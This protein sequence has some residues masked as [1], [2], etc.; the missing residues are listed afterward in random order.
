MVYRNPEEQLKAMK[1]NYYPVGDFR[2]KTSIYYLRDHLN[3]P[4]VTV[5]LMKDPNGVVCRGLALCSLDDNPSKKDIIETRILPAKNP[6]YNSMTVT[7]ILAGGRTIAEQRA[8]LAFVL[9]CSTG[10]IIREEAINVLR[11]VG[12][13]QWIWKSEFDIEPRTMFEKKLIQQM[14]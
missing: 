12:D 2:M 3:A 7:E 13:I 9:G 14:N 11:H 10:A 4:R 6:I 5:C 8:E 1:L